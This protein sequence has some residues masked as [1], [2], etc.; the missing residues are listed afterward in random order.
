[1]K[2]IITICISLITLAGFA[3]DP[4]LQQNNPKL[5][6]QATKITQ[7][8]NDQLALTGKQFMLFQKKVEEYLIRR[9]EIEKKY[10]DKDKLDRLFKLQEVE[11]REMND[12]LT[13]PQLNL[14]KEI[15]SKI[16]PLATVNKD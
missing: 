7:A 14:Y 8:Y 12:I 2:F 5:D 11:T 13:R 4:M 6:D 9:E 16:Q 10:T 3:Q 1:M 15:K